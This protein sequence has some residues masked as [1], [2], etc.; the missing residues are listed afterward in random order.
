MGI[1]LAEAEQ[2]LQEYRCFRELFSRRLQPGARPIHSEDDA[3]VSPVDGCITTLGTV[4]QGRLIQAKGISYSLAD[5]LENGELAQKFEGGT[6]ITLY[7]RPKDYHRIHCPFNG[8]VLATQPIGGA[9]FPVKP[10]V[11]RNLRG[12]MTR[13]ERL[14]ILLETKL[15]H[16]AM[17]CVAAAGVGTITKLFGRTGNGDQSSSLEFE[18]KKGDEVAAFNMGSTVI[19]FF[20]PG[21]VIFEPLDIG[22]EVRMGQILARSVAHA[23]A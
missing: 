9:L 13:N 19:L 23:Q 21:K 15:G 20:E 3:I 4:E 5:L 8:K 1:D 2:T 11:V 6:F 10:Y 16:V 12:L 18:L 7:L 17:V 22:Q 14:L